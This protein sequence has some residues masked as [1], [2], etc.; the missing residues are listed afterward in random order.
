MAQQPIITHVIQELSRGGGA[1]A[2]M[3][4]AHYHQ[5]L[6]G[7]KHQIVSLLPADP[8]AVQIARDLGIEVK[9]TS[10]TATLHTI[11]EVSDIVQVSWWNAVDIYQFLKMRLPACRLLGWFH[12]GGQAA[13]QVI[14]NKLADFFDLSLACSPFTRGHPSLV[15]A[16]AEDPKRVGMVYGATD[17]SRIGSIAKI[18]HTGFNIGYIGTVDFIKMHPAYV[19]MSAAANISDAQFMLCGS[20][21]G[22]PAIIHQAKQLQS[23]RKF[24]YLGYVED[25][26]ALLSVLDAYGYPLREDTYAASEMNLQEIMYAGIPAVV[27]PYGG[28][29]DLII[30]GVTGLIASTER[31]YSQ[32]LEF[33]YHHPEQRARIGEKAR[34]YATMFFGAE[35]AAKSIAPLYSQLLEQPKRLRAWGNYVAERAIRPDLSDL[36]FSTADSLTTVTGGYQFFIE[37][38]GNYG[39]DFLISTYSTDITEQLAAD[40]RIAASQNVMVQSGLRPYRQKFPTDWRLG[41]WLTIAEIK[42]NQLQAALVAIFDSVNNGGDIRSLLTLQWIAEQLKESALVAELN[43]I[44][45]AQGSS[46]DTQKQIKEFLRQLT[47]A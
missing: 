24:R 16:A 20:G 42:N 37:S 8:N 9:V 34:E 7:A 26:P 18:P 3:Y 40:N 41:Y 13:P 21:E 30:D 19:R 25:M 4:L 28:I 27:F 38:L 35:N 39:A 6:T 36:Y 5:K 32:A 33:L 10:D 15:S 22:I 23:E 47:A 29:K 45:A 11:L 43:P 2:T 44:I 46:I 12:V 14:T 31:E 1:R 17:F